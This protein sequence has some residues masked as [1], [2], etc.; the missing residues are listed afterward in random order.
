MLV[1]CVGLKRAA[2]TLQYQICREV[3]S[4]KLELIDYGYT[5]F[6]KDIQKA[7]NNNSNGIIKTHHY[8]DIFQRYDEKKD[9]KYLTSYRDLRESSISA[10]EAYNISYNKLISNK[11]FESEID[12]YYEFKKINNILFQEYNM[13]KNDLRNS[14]QQICDFLNITLSD[15]SQSQLL[16]NFNRDAQLNKIMAYRRSNKFKVINI[17][18]NIFY[19]INP[20]SFLQRGI[21][22][23]IDKNTSLHHKHINVKNNINWKSYYSKEQ[24]E[25]I[26]AI[27]GDWLI[28][29]GYEEDYGW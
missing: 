14:I 21:L 13:L 8:Y 12:C 5:R 4:Q 6:E 16:N 1:I 9:I 18:N 27:I 29:A 19:K 3:L 11:W 24:Q 20:T 2:S 17:I 25:I 7:I 23:N 10:M 15:E 26:K 28:D 22:Y